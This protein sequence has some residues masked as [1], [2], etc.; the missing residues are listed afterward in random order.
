MYKFVEAVGN[1]LGDNYR[2]MEEHFGHPESS[3]I[4]PI[5]GWV[6]DEDQ[7]SKIEVEVRIRRI[8]KRYQ[9]NIEDFKADYWDGEFVFEKKFYR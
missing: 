5:C 4:S 9:D 7:I 6:L 2:W 3:D 1:R 8:P